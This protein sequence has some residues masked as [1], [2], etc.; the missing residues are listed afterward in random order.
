MARSG[1]AC[2]G[3]FHLWGVMADAVEIE[4]LVI[5]GAM[6]RMAEIFD[7]PSSSVTFYSSSNRM[8]LAQRVAQL[9]KGAQETVLWPKLFLHVNTLALAEQGSETAYSYK[10][11]SR[12]GIYYQVADS[13]NVLRNIILV[14]T[15]FT[16]ETTF[17]TDDYFKA[18]RFGKQWLIA[19]ARNS[20]NFTINYGSV[21]LDIRAQ[22]DNS[23]NTPD[24]DEAVNHPNVYEYVASVNF[25][26]FV[27]QT[28]EREVPVIQE[29]QT[30]ILLNQTDAAVVNPPTFIASR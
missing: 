17:M 6:Q 2:A 15:V 1:F 4:H 25:W 24:R 8:Q 21:A 3:H 30:S 28:E 27:S 5:R 10:Q 13:Q 20:F 29:R 11:M 26:G 12:D 23:V 9:L 7:M 18:L 14:P 22:G 19:T 16:V